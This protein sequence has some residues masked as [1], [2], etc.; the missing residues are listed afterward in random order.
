MGLPAVGCVDCRSQRS[1]RRPAKRERLFAASF[2]IFAQGLPIVFFPPIGHPF[3]ILLGDIHVGEVDSAAF[4][5]L[6]EVEDQ[7]RIGIASVEMGASPALDDEFA[8]DD[9][10]GRAA[11]HSVEGVEFAAGFGADFHGAAGE[12]GMAFGVHIDVVK[13]PGGRGKMDGLFDGGGHG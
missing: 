12:C 9:G 10:H 2:E 1:P 8:G 6:D 11:E 13:F 3:V 7:D 4:A 5:G